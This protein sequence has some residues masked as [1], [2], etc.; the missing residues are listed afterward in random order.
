MERARNGGRLPADFIQI[1][2][3]IISEMEKGVLNS[4]ESEERGALAR[5]NKKYHSVKNV[6]KVGVTGVREGDRSMDDS[7]MKK[8]VLFKKKKEEEEKV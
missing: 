6:D 5:G 1:L 4:K 8:P 7:S 2:E 3:G